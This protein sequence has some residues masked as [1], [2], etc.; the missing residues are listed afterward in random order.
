MMAGA[1]DAA[2]SAAH[3]AITQHEARFKKMKLQ[4][5]YTCTAST[6]CRVWL[7]A[8]RGW[9]IMRVSG[10][11]PARIATPRAF[12]TPRGRNTPPR[13]AFH[14]HYAD[15]S[16]LKRASYSNRS[17]PATPFL[18]PNDI[19]RHLISALVIAIYFYIISH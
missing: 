16:P 9:P 2:S 6:A 5:C 1:A 14:D 18:L 12:R 11:P 3:F 17:Q 4:T 10:R 19:F 7:A 15:I 13:A 8:R